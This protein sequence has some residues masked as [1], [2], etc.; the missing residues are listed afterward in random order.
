MLNYINKVINYEIYNRL[1]NTHITTDYCNPTHNL[2][3][4]VP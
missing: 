2:S 1:Q 4:N 3:K